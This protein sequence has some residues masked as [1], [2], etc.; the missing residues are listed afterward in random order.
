MSGNI[1]PNNHIF[2]ANKNFWTEMAGKTAQNRHF[3]PVLGMSDHC[4]QTQWHASDYL[5]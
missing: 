4:N 1:T 3:T 5:I 2:D